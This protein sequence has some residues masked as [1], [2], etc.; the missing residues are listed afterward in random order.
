MSF[1]RQQVA[2]VV[3]LGFCSAIF[4]AEDPPNFFHPVLESL[5]LAMQLLGYLMILLSAFFS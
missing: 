5:C 4:R 3:T 1:S 2:M